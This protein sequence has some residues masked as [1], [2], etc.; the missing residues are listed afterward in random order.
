MFLFSNVS[1]WGLGPTQHLFSGY[2]QVFQHEY[3]SLVQHHIL[4]LTI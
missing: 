1:G 4:P 2:L 3:Y